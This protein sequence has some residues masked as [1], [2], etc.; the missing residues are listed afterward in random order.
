MAKKK[1]EPEG[2]AGLLVN[3]AKAI[4]KAVG[5]VAAASGAKPEVPAKLNQSEAASVKPGKLPK[6]NK[7]RLPR[8]QKKMQKKAQTRSSVPIAPKPSSV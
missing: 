3:A 5:K 4:G 7:Q 6:K 1:A 8:R 2:D